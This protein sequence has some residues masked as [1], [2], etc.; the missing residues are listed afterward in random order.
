MVFFNKCLYKKAF[1][2][3]KPKKK[4]QKGIVRKLTK[5][6]SKYFKVNYKNILKILKI[7]YVCVNSGI[8]AEDAALTA[9]LT[10][11]LY[12]LYGGV[13]GVLSSFI[14]INNLVIQVKPVYNK[15]YFDVKIQ[16]ILKIKKAKAIKEIF[17]FF[18]WII[19]RIIKKKL[20]AYKNEG[21]SHM[22][23]YEH[24]YAKH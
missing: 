11:I 17:K 3:S 7:K 6:F 22:R 9:V 15:F 4:P 13:L 21:S 12:D 8:G 24:G 1:Y 14:P 16:C 23:S 2:L 19:K 20:E 18:I 5:Y 10:G